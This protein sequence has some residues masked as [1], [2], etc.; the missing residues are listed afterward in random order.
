M[1]SDSDND[2]TGRVGAGVRWAA[3]RLYPRYVSETDL[4][5]RA[6]ER[7]LTPDAA[8]LDAGCGS[9]D[10]FAHRW[11]D[12][13]R[14]LV[15][16]DADPGAAR[17]PYVGS[18]TLASLDHLPFRGGSFDVAFARYV[19]EH[20]ENPAA[21]LAE[22]ARVIKPGG[23]VV[24]LTPNRRHYVTLISR[25]LP[26]AAH[27]PIGRVLCGVKPEGMFPTAYRAND[28]RTLVRLAAEAG[29]R[30]RELVAYEARPNYLAW[31]LPTFLL[32]VAYERLV[33]RINGLRR[34]RVSLIAVFERADQANET[35]PSNVDL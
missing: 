14:L 13:V 19:M 26:F 16:C 2:L 22:L 5:T 35:R 28:E 6:V 20:L 11:R 1:S 32:G 9:G 34:F 31:S 10:Y 29:L 3:A 4:F 30:P 27:R 8:V 24:I 17:N 15:G 21:I 18:V 23:V 7:C 25:L 12:R 33:N